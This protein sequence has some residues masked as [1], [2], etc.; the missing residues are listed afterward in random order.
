MKP[1][2][3]PFYAVGEDI[4]I[5]KS[6]TPSNVGIKSVIIKRHHRSSRDGIPLT[7]PLCGKGVEVYETKD[8]GEETFCQCEI[9]K[10]PK[11][12]M[13]FEELMDAL[14]TIEI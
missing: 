7:C 2:M 3:N 14:K 10:R 1:L 12:G 4:T 5:I 6:S 11:P 13:N 8:T 9:R